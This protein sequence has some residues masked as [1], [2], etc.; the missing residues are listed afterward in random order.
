MSVD[1]VLAIA[2]AARGNVVMII[3]GLGVSIPLVVFSSNLIATLMDRY[4][5]IV[6]L[7]GAILGRVGG[8]NDHVRPFCYQGFAPRGIHD[9]DC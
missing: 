6:Y 3:F 4:P 8:G 1:N 7:G 9:L 5:V 2:G